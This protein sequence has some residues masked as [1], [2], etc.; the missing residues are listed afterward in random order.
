MSSTFLPNHPHENT[1]KKID[2]MYYDVVIPFKEETEGI[3][4]YEETRSEPIIYNPNE[5]FIAIDRFQIPLSAIPLFRYDNS[6][7]YLVYLEYDNGIVNVKYP[8]SLVYIPTNANADGGKYSSY[9]S[10]YSYHTITNMLNIAYTTAFGKLKTAYPAIPHTMAPYF[11]YNLQTQTIDMICETAYLTDTIGS[12][13]NDVKIGCNFIARD[14]FLDSMPSYYNGTASLYT[15]YAFSFI[16]QNVGNNHA[17]AQPGSTIPTLPTPPV[18]LKIPSEYRTVDRINAL[19]SI[20]I[21]T[22]TLPILREFHSLKGSNDGSTKY[23]SIMIDFQAELDDLGD[24]RSVMNYF[25]Q[26]N[27][28]VIQLQSNSPIHS[29]DFK[30]YWKGNDGYLYPLSIGPGKTMD[31][32]FV[33]IRKE[34]YKN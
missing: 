16:I 28:K 4:E 19:N 10:V 34:G 29:F 6:N 27:F 17:Y 24:T 9:W 25:S 18:Y 2:R 7:P 1:S 12:P 26:G 31:I 20:V 14:T 3:A 13:T 33:F 32:K 22:R 21:T 23:Q 5:Y 8:E 30:V 15:D 11:E